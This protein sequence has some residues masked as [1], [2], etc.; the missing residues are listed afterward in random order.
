MRG[1]R[2]PNRCTEAGLRGQMLVIDAYAPHRRREPALRSMSASS[3]GGEKRWNPRV[4]GQ[5]ENEYARIMASLDLPYPKMMDVAVRA[6]LSCTQ[7]AG[8]TG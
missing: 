3:I 5:A 4:A 8:L 2:S 7:T 1:A 6:N